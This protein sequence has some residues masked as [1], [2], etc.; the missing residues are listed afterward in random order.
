MAEIDNL[1]IKISAEAKAAMGSIDNLV[2]RIGNISKALNQIDVGQISQKFSALSKSDGFSNI[3]KSAKEAEKVINNVAKKAVKEIKVK[4]TFD[5]SDYQRVT[6]ELRKKFADDGKNVNFSGNLSDLE[7]K[8]QALGTELD[9]L[10]QKEQKIISVGK[11][12]PESSAFYNLQYDIS[13]AANKMDVLSQKIKSLRA[14][15]EFR[16]SGLAE[17]QIQTE[18]LESSVKEI[19]RTSSVSAQSLN[20]NADAMRAVFGEG[21]DKIQNWSQAVGQF[22]K[23]AGMA[24]NNLGKDAD[25]AAEKLKR[26]ES[27]AANTSKFSGLSGVAKKISSAFSDLGNTSKRTA[28]QI[29]TLNSGFKKLFRTIAPFLGIYEIFRFGKNAVETASNLTE[30][31]NVVDVTFGKY[32]SLVEEMAKTSIPDFG[33][34]EL[35][36]KDV[37]SR[38]QAMGTAMGFSQGKMAEMSVELTKLTADMASF[39]NV[40]QKDVAK[41][42]ESIFTGQTRPLRQ[43]GLDLT[44]ATLQEWALKNG[45][46]ANIQSMSQAEKTM[47]RYQYVMANTGAAQGDFARTADTWANQ[48]RILRQNLEQLAAVIGG[49]LINALKPLVKALNTALGYIIAFAKTVSD[50]LGAIFGWKYES[51]GGIA[52]DFSSAEASAGGVAD[53][54]GKAA[55]NAKKLKQYMLGFDELHVISPADEAAGATSGAGG[56]GGTNVPDADG[57]KWTKTDSI[58]EGYE[59]DIKSLYELG[60]YIGNALSEAMESIDWDAIYEKARNFGSGLATFLNGL[61][62]PRLFENLGITIAG[63]LNTV[64]HFLDSFGETFDWTNFGDS[65]AAGINGFFKTFDFKLLADTLNVWANG[66]LNAAITAMEGI[67]WSMIGRQIGTFLA[68][69]DFTTILSNIGK[70][71][72]EAIKA[73][74]ELWKGS[75]D[76]APIETTIITALA[77]IKFLGIGSIV[78]SAVSK[79]IVKGIAKKLGVEIG[80]DMTI[81]TVLSTAL[82]G[83]IATLGGMLSTKIGALGGAI[84]AAISSGWGIP[85]AAALAGLFLI[86]TNWDSIKEAVLPVFEGIGERLG[87]IWETIKT[88]VGE[89]IE[90]FGEKIQELPQRA[91]EAITS[92]G[93]WFSSLPEKIAYALGYALGSV[94]KWAGDI[95]NCLS[96]KIPQII[97]NVVTWFSELPE[98]IYNGIIGLIE[99]VQEWATNVWTAFSE[100]VTQIVTD[101]VTWFTELPEKIFDAIQTFVTETLPTWAGNVT[102]WVSTEIPK[103]VQGIADWFKELP[104]KI[105]SVIEGV[106]DSIKR[107][108]RYILDG[109]F[110]GLSGVKTK[111][112]QWKDSF[113]QGFKDALGIH[114]PSKVAEDEIGT[115]F[116]EGISKG[117]ANTIVTAKD[118]AQQV[119]DGIREVFDNMSEIDLSSKIKLN[120][121]DTSEELS[122]G[123]GGFSSE[124]NTGIDEES[125]TAAIENVNMMGLGMNEVSQSNMSVFLEQWTQSWGEAMNILYSTT[126]SMW[127][128][129]TGFF[130]QSMQLWQAFNGTLKQQLNEYFTG[131]YNYIYD[132]FDAIRQTTQHISDE[133]TKMLN[134]LVS[135]ANS[136]SRLTGQHYSHVTGYTMAKAERIQIKQFAAGGFP[137]KGSLFIAGEAG[138]E[139]V[140][141]IGGRTA[142]ANNEQIEISIYNAV[143][144]AMNQAFAMQNTTQP[145][146]LNQ[147]ITLDGDVIYRNQQKIAARRGVDLGLGAFQR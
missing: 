34:S 21:A 43:Y 96:E 146:E 2:K 142:V 17:A 95:V 80:A 117:I 45:L 100:K 123:L 18:K 9:K 75:F 38:F 76:V 33:M 141:S 86:F 97:N 107:I 1:S 6:E 10:L 137:E 132:V 31:Q 50:A 57:G 73:A 44:Q 85:I 74:I 22:G 20:Y 116:G 133:V 60:K 112:L 25:V 66:I 108:G 102:T 37:S 88:T 125:A 15:D 91:S 104:S 3:T 118:L 115:Y 14:A 126:Q 124:S 90:Q 77:G 39:Y 29:G 135:N 82:G 122:A 110:E 53:E 92:V 62:S 19:Q 54:T 28:V 145:I 105:M 99:K 98:K 101:V 147:K 41:S 138:A 42:L 47:L 119:V 30:I 69:I 70:L 24:L 55:D 16:I 111:V 144:S 131:M 89:K 68:E 65:I 23:N 81:K 35:T 143:L 109:I 12:S 78:G 120:K 8:Y 27:V 40:S 94:V 121:P 87:E 67:D 136:L 5:T 134:R 71:I 58:L 128:H 84:S 64:L 46:D 32:A 113:V 11:T 26:V 13:E 130:G 106:Y 4:A 103:I 127:Q 61:I 51:G 129:I 114:S 59:S 93:E 140:G 49:T 52:E 48:T 139:M 36:V 79:E 56:G 83:K 72:W 7:K 63:A